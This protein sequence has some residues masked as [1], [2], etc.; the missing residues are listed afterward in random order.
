MKIRKLLASEQGIAF[1]TVIWIITIMAMIGTTTAFVTQSHL[2]NTELQSDSTL[3]FNIAEAG[4]ERLLSNYGQDYPKNIPSDITPVYTDVAFNNGNYTTSISKDNNVNRTGNILITSTGTYKKTSRTIIVSVRG[5]PEIFNYGIIS[6]NNLEFESKIKGQGYALINGNVHAN[7]N[8]NLEGSHI[9]LNT[10]TYQGDSGWQNNPYYDPQWA[11]T[12]MGDVVPNNPAF[13]GNY[14]ATDTS[15]VQF[16]TLDYEYYR[17]QSNFTNQQV[18]VYTGN[19]T[20]WTVADFNN[21]FAPSP[22]YTSSIV[23]FEGNNGDGEIKISGSGTITATILTGTSSNNEGEIEIMADPGGT[24]NIMPAIGL[25]LV[26]DELEIGGTVNIG[27]QDNGAIVIASK[28]IEI[29][30]KAQEGGNHHHHHSIPSNVTMWGSLAIGKAG[31]NEAELELDGEDNAQNNLNL[32]F[33]DSINDNL[34]AGWDKWG[35]VLMYKDNWKE[36]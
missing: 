35:T 10:P 20:D 2:S 26:G 31:S 34:P 18:F 33:T 8:V 11:L 3:A 16:P 15:Q 36:K 5:V 25:A 1:T 28:E 7:G 19:R 21:F 6:N 4:V 9:F 30:G 24:I 14:N 13:T 22:P 27:T 32:N 17:Q 12:A 29:E 23:V